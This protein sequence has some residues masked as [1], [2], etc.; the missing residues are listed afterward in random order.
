MI[1]VGMERGVVTEQDEVGH[2]QGDGW[3]GRGGVELGEVKGGGR[4]S[5]GQRGVK[6]GF[7]GVAF[8]RLTTREPLRLRDGQPGGLGWGGRVWRPHGGLYR[9]S[10]DSHVCPVFMQIIRTSLNIFFGRSNHS[11]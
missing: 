3:G 9:L 7:R 11:S 10:G 2:E 5:D 4:V 6:V 1:R 8:Q